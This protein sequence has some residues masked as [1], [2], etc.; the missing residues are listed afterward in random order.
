M[1]LSPQSKQNR[2]VAICP[3]CGKEATI[4]ISDIELN[5]IKKERGLIQKAILHKDHVVIV[6]VDGQC[7]IRR[8]YAY[9]TENIADDQIKDFS[10]SK[11]YIEDEQIPDLGSLLKLMLNHS[12]TEG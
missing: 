1:K 6:Y 12:K 10:E 8:T 4:L 3:S 7:R 5:K 11:S 9:E 2:I